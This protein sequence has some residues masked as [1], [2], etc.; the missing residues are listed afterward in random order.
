MVKP[1][2]NSDGT[3]IP[4]TLYAA[5]NVANGN[6][7]WQP[8]AW[9]DVYAT[10]DD[11][12]A[13]IPI[14][15]EGDRCVVTSYTDTNGNFIPA[16]VYI[17]T[18][19]KEGTLYWKEVSPREKYFVYETKEAANTDLVNRYVG[20]ICTVLQHVVD[21]TAYPMSHYI[22]VKKGD[23]LEWKYLN[24][25]G[26]Y[27]DEAL[28]D[29]GGKYEGKIATV[30]AYVDTDGKYHPAVTYIGKLKE[31]GTFYWEKLK[32]HTIYDTKAIADNNIFLHEEGDNCSVL[33]YTTDAGV[34]VPSTTYVL[35]KD[36]DGVLYWRDLEPRSTYHVYDT[37]VLADADLANCEEADMATVKQ[38]TLDDGTVEPQ[39]TYTAC[40]DADGNLYWEYLNNV[41]K[42]F[43][44]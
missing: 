16:S 39:T 29:N 43:N 21:T 9:N 20:D 13:Q 41:W 36:K 2:F 19:D 5:T 10:I 3:R 1:K 28:R 23:D 44:E 14:H 26:I 35:S 18:K 12:N 22:V 32:N 31:D 33:S 17:L 15:R 24:D 34:F 11:A 4:A 6:M 37:K 27:P 25:Y 38:H 40:K 30:N 7:I 42:E 8:L